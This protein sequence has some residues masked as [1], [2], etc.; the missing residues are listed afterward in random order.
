MKNN[1]YIFGC[2]YSADFEMSGVK[3]QY[4]S[5]KNGW[6]KSWSE[7]L[8][9][10]L[11]MTLV[12]KARG[13]FGNDA[14]FDEF[15][16]ESDKIKKDDIVI[17]GWSYFNRFRVPTFFNGWKW[18]NI[19]IFSDTPKLS[20]KT[21]QEI[22]VSRDCI[23]YENEIHNRETLIKQYSKSKGFKVYFWNA[24][25]P[26][27]NEEGYLLQNIEKKTPQDTFINFVSR[28]GGQ[29]I[30]EE[31]NGIVDDNHLGENGHIIQANLF[32]DEIKLTL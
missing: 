14:I 31:T 16:I 6:P 21:I 8:S 5:Y 23:L 24:S 32:Y 17:I 15:C 10:K 7:I 11:N 30:I 22:V 12:N 20:K 4:E 2:S 18:D 3:K 13:G 1:L 9:E 29:K 25:Y 27:E 28:L 26:F 19:S